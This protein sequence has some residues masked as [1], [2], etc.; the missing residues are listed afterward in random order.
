MGP[1]QPG[2]QIQ[3]GFLEEVASGMELKNAQ[4]SIWPGRGAGCV[5]GRCW[6]TAQGVLCGGG[7]RCHRRGWLWACGEAEDR[8]FPSGPRVAMM[9]C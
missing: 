5:R 9:R 1:S 8:A 2:T 4:K 3:E 7:G 6:A